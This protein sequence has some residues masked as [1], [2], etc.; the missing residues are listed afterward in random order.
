MQFFKYQALGND[1]V[2]IDPAKF[3]LELTPTRIQLICDRHVGVG[4]DGICYGPLPNIAQPL[5]MRFWNPDGN[6][7]EK[8]GN[9]LRIFARYLWD[10]GYVGSITFYDWN[11][12]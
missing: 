11:W 8:S 6:M 1:M 7:A 4:A 3:D 9:G 5:T 10:A 12:G 2:V